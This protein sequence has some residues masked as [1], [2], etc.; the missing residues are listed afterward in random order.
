MNSAAG[1]D[2]GFS[3]F[4]SSNVATTINVYD[5]TNGTGNVLASISLDAQANENCPVNAT[6]FYCNWTSVGVDFAG[7]AH[8]VDFGGASN[9]TG[10]D[11]ITIGSGTAGA[12]ELPEPA[13]IAL[14]GIAL[15]GAALGLR[16]R[17]AR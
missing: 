2:T 7:T 5:G 17:H 6:A 3:F 1:F 9:H 16:R 11:D 10:F 12:G 4:Y 15:A 14:V 13:S 8:S